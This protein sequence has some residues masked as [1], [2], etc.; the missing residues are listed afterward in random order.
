MRPWTTLCPGLRNAL[1]RPSIPSDDISP[2][3]KRRFSNACELPT[4]STGP[5][6]AGR[7]APA[8]ASVACCCLLLAACCYLLRVA[9]LSLAYCL[10]L[11]SCE[12]L[13]ACCLLLVGACRLLIACCLL[14]IACCLLFVACCLSRVACCLLL[15]VACVLLVA[16]A[17]SL[18]EGDPEPVAVLRLV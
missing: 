2:C 4:P 6:K 14:P 17:H 5:W 10:L 3:G 7:R 11:A 15:L 12:L 9:C 18:K 13:V 8:P 1:G 16:C